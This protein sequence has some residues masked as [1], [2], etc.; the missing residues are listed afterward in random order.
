[1]A[2]PLKNE[3][4]EAFVNKIGDLLAER[5]QSFNLDGF[6]C[7]II[8]ENW[9]A[10]ELKERMRHITN[11]VHAHSS[12]DYPEQLKL[13]VEIS[14]QFGGLAGMTFPDYVEVYG[15]D[16]LK[17]SVEAMK[18]MTKYSSSE[19]A[20]RPYIVKNKKE[21]MESMLDWSRDENEHI[22]RLASEGC[23][24][25][26]PWA[27][28]LPE[29]KKDPSLILPILENL[30]TDDSLYVRK[31]V[32]NNIND[33]TKD[34]PEVALS[35]CEQ[36]YGE[37]PHTNWIVKHGLR[38]LLK[39]GN[40]RALQIIGFNDKAKFKVPDL[41]LSDSKVKLGSDMKFEFQILN[42]E[43]KSAFAKVGFVVSYQKANGSLSDK[44]FHV[45]EKEFPSSAPSVFNKKLSFRDLTTRRH[46]PGLH[47][48]GVLVNGKKLAEQDFEL[49]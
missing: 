14:S 4:N 24:P 15:L 22:R 2:E 19:F 39:N 38:T 30:K 28:A 48:I 43:P 49:V 20:I 46:H 7:S 34:N 29:F 16:Y 42:M 37:N 26:L 35:L 8:N 44:I 13:M 23:R 5:D 21:V 1:M 11:M 33:I 10:R 12:L 25:R 32:A 47:K 18:E 45:A 9:E 3:Y 41:K 31:S 36:W 27:M 17:E 40:K 6:V